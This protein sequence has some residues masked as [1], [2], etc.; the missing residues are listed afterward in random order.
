MLG[1]ASDQ[2]TLD[3][4]RL[5]AI[6]AAGFVLSCA[7]VAISLTGSEPDDVAFAIALGLSIAAPTAVGLYAWR[8]GVHQRFGALL[9]I[10]GL[11]SFLPSLSSSSQDLVYS[12]GR[13]AVWPTAVALIYLLLAFPA[14]RLLGRR[15]RGLVWAGGLLVALLYV[16]SA[17]FVDRY[18]L[19]SQWTACQRRL[20][21]Q[22]LH[23]ACVAARIRRRG[24]GAVA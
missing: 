12:I 23:G 1:S 21:G 5:I 3:T 9:V 22:R 13:V 14:G 16:P 11:A 20:P 10:A 8:T 4:P 7:A 24:H 17:L 2:L 18:P 6:G 15:E 19:P